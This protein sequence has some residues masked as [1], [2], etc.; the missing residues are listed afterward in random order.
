MRRHTLTA[1]EGRLPLILAVLLALLC[2]SLGWYTAGVVFGVVLLLLMVYLREPRREVPSPPLGILSPVD[3]R[4]V[5]T[6]PDQDP[7]LERPCLR[8]TIAMSLF[9]SLRLRGPMEGKV[10][11]FWNAVPEGRA[12]AFTG[13]HP[14]SAQHVQ[15]D[16]Q[17]DLVLCL[18]QP[19]FLPQAP[20]YVSTGERAGQG[21]NCGF[22]WFP[23]RVHLL[24]PDNVSVS[25]QVGDPVQAGV[26]VLASLVRQGAGP[27]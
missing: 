14:V 20:F 22:L 5:E 3:G 23:A 26:Q 25:C 18:Q 12:A 11:N 10:Q 21:K 13:G 17:D 19:S 6:G 16:E 1:P 24:L 7:W 27:T 9:D 4:V 2:V 15:S 8:I